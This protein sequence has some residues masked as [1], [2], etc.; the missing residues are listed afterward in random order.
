MNAG[1]RQ[2]SP[3]SISHLFYSLSCDCYRDTTCLRSSTTQR[4]LATPGRLSTSRRI[5]CSSRFLLLKAASDFSLADLQ[6]PGSLGMPLFSLTLLT[7]SN[8]LEDCIEV[9]V[10][11]VI[12]NHWIKTRAQTCAGNNQCQ[13]SSFSARPAV[14]RNITTWISEGTGP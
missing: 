14:R 7:R 4:Q 5:V 12:L 3:R 13:L 2:S 1:V 9:Y 10:A 11:R 6:P 8:N